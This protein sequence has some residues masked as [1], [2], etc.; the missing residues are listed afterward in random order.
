MAMSWLLTSMAVFSFV[1]GLC[2]GTLPAVTAAALDGAQ[3]AIKLAVSMAGTLCL[4]NGVLALLEESGLSRTLAALFRPL[5]RRLLPR[6]SRDPETLEAVSAN[7]SANLLGLG[8]AATPP[9]IRAAQKM[10]AGWNGVASDELCLLVVLNTASVQLLPT[11]VASLRAASGSAA[12]FDILPAV[13]ITSLTS[14]AAGLMM[15]KLLSRRR[16]P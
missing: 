9:G 8:N 15:A 1:F 7:L 13:W 4:W 2:H 11:T 16:L 3:T 10:A 5:L 12:P 14:V 6:S